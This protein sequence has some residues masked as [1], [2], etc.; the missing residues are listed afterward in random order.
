L[1][2]DVDDALGD[3]GGCIVAAWGKAGPVVE[4]DDFHVAVG[5]HYA[6][7]AINLDVELVGGTVADLLEVFGLEFQPL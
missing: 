6:V 4:V 5:A 2:D 1:F 3:V 7:A